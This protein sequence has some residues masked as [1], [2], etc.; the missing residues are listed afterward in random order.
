MS[1]VNSAAP[2]AKER[3]RQKTVYPMPTKLNGEQLPV[4][5]WEYSSILYVGVVSRGR[6]RL[7]HRVPCHGMK[8]GSIPVGPVVNDVRVG[9]AINPALKVVNGLVVPDTQLTRSPYV[10]PSG[11]IGKL[12]WLRTR[13][14]ER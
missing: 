6:K 4:K 9:R 7:E 1:S 5:K 8:A 14:I 3:T 10:C 13:S 11:G 2:R 12:A